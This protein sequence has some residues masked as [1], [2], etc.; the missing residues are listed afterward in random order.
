MAGD[1]ILIEA[2]GEVATPGQQSDYSFDAS[3][4][5]TVLLE[6][7]LSE[8]STYWT[9]TGPDQGEIFSIIRSGVSSLGPQVLEQAGE[10]TLSV[11]GYAEE[12]GAYSFALWNVPMPD[13]FEI[14]LASVIGSE[15]GT[16]AGEIETPGV[17]DVYTFEAT[18]GQSIFIEV[19][20][21]NFTSYWV[22]ADQDDTQVFAGFRSGGS[23][24]GL[25]Q[26]ERGGVYTLTVS[27]YQAETGTY[28][29][30]LWEV[31][32]PDTFAVEIGQTV[33]PEMTSAGA[34]S[35]E[36][37]GAQD[38]YTFES[39]SGQSIFVEVLQA[40]FTA[41]W[42]ITGPDEEQIFSGFRGGDSSLGVLSL[43]TDGQYTL[44]VSGYNAETGTYRAKLWDVP[45][46]DH[47]E[48]ALGQSISEGTPEAGAGVIETPGVQDVYTF[49]AAQGQSIQLEIATAD[50]SVYWVVEHEDGEQIFSGYR[51][52]ESIIGPITL[53]RAGPYRL[54]VSGYDRES[55]RY[56]FT[57]SEP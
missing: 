49:D 48:I 52:A 29:A 31:P 26:L 8:L 56:R 7:R 55:G 1:S 17:K 47:F 9:L 15:T 34:G 3:A 43:E 50:F 42:Q 20:E 14:P 10:Y 38:I 35:I 18:A 5:Q 22:L 36:S 24:I 16:G 19:P 28:R 2:E 11:S 45:A 4:G 27:G 32:A 33:A 57:I 53:E 40:D 25:V 51:S 44:T 21:A 54:I 13:S 12:T 37:P 23:N 41:Y 39:V 6:I 30:R 46:P